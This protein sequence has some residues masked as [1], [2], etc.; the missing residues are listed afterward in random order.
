VL[1]IDLVAI[2]LDAAG[3]VLSVEHI[4]SAIEE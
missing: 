4:E 1:R 2:D 3:R